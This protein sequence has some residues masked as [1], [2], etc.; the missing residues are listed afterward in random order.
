ML[1]EAYKI[2]LPA[3]EGPLD[4]LMHLIRKND[5]QVENIPIVTILEQYLHYINL[6]QELNIDLAGEFILMAA[7]LAH[8]KSKM[9]L[10]EEKSEEEDEGEDPRAEL[11]RRLLEYQRFKDVASRLAER[12]FLGR[13]VFIHP[14]YRE[15]GNIEEPV[16]Q[17]DSYKL[18]LAFN[19]VL[20][21]LK[22]EKYHE[23]AM[24]RL[25]VSQRIYQLIE[26]FKT[27]SSITFEE[28]FE[29]AQTKGECI[30]TFLA[31][32]EMIRLKLIRVWQAEAQ[33]AIRIELRGQTEIPTNLELSSEFDEGPCPKPQGEF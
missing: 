1:Q 7:E 12:P 21:R 18:L 20:K 2:N 32:L 11:A 23:V 3:F 25:S 9:L 5:V 14:P 27:A 31:L 28:V 17:A 4:L 8:I 30:V 10:P 33:A 24:E 15:T 19:G 13:D 6:M 22:P 16:L 26:Y 29:T